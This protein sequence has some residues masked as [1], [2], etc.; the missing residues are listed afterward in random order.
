M[1]GTEKNGFTL[2]EL[3]VTIAILGIL[4]AIALPSYQQFVTELAYDDAGK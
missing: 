3:L 2:V 4:M 1:P